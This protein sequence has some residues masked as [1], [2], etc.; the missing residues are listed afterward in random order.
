MGGNEV[1]LHTTVFLTTS[2]KGLSWSRCPCCHDGS[3]E[4]PTW[5]PYIL[6]DKNLGPCPPATML[7]VRGKNTQGLEKT[8]SW[9]PSVT[10]NWWLSYWVWHLL[11]R[12]NLWKGMKPLMGIIA[13]LP[14]S[15]TFLP[16]AFSGN[17]LVRNHHWQK[18]LKNYEP[19]STEVREIR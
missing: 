7:E 14:A 18:D 4:G 10:L 13:I 5:C 1:F 19:P 16:V 12:F 3:V 9:W 17:S 15:P 8:L 6:Q 2:E 11:F